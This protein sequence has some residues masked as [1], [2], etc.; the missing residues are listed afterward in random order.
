MLYNVSSL[1]DFPIQ[2]AIFFNGQNFT[3]AGQG[4]FDGT[5]H[6]FKTPTG[7]GAS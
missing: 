5:F 2:K 3:V 6:F 4:E 1:I 7:T